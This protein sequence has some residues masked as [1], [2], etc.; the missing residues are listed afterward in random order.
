VGV[1][2]PSWSSST[3]LLYAGG[4]VV[5]A[6]AALGLQVTEHG[7]GDAGFVGWSALVFAVLLAIAYGF[8][9]R[10]DWVAGGV[11]AFSSVVAWGIFI[12]ALFS[13]WGWLPHE[14]HPFDGFHVGLLLLELLVLA[15]AFALRRAFGFPLLV[16][17]QAAVG[18]YFVTDL[19]SNGGGWSAVVTFVVGVVYL[20]VGST[21]DRGPRRPYGFWWH[22]A[23]GLLIGG[24]MLHFWHSSAGDWI[25]IGIAGLVY[26]GL[27]ARLGRSSWTVLGA[28]GLFLVA[29][30]FIRRWSGL[31]RAFFSFFGGPAHVKEWV[32]P[33]VLAVLGFLYVALG[34][35]VGRRRSDTV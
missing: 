33:V 19:V 11:F 32:A 31:D 15:Q 4:L 3:F 14:Q 16:A 30:Y 7:Y 13:W 22:V 28:L 17:A 21:V 27:G 10:G 2:K 6:A 18:W 29:A 12:A 35:L 5:L 26:I 8:R 25:L 23:S 34:L 9:R 20:I 24:A 1:A